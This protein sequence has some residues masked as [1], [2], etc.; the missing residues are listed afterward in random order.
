VRDD[1]TPAAVLPEPGAAPAISAHRGGRE[2]SAAGTYQAYRA[3]LASGADYIEVDVRRTADGVLVACHRE[4]FGPG[5][6]VAALSYGRLCRVAGFEVPRLDETMLLLAGRAGAHLDLKDPAC[7]GAAVR[8]ALGV[9][10]PGR[11]LVTTRDQAPAAELTASHPALQVGVTIGGD[12]PETARFVARRVRDRTV[13][14]LDGVLAARAGWAV[15]H[16]RLARGGLLAACRN[17]GLRT[18]VWTVNRDRALARWLACADVDALVTDRP[19]RAIAL[20]GY[21]GR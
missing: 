20:R 19:A 17:R 10:G 13:S 16:Q 15:V 21:C 12:L 11:V 14:R 6:A 1:R 5:R 3:A 9:L 18:L 2:Y 8:H 4:Q 7:S